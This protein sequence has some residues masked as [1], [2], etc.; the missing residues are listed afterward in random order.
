M[1]SIA[2]INDVETTQHE[3][4]P[5]AP[6][7]E[8]QEFRLTQMYHESLLHMQAG[9][10]KQAQKLLQIIIEDP[11]SL[12]AESEKTASSDPMRQLRFLSFRNLAEAF[13]K[14]GSL[15]HRAALQCY[16]NA[17]S[18]DE[19]DVTLWN[20]LGTLACSLDSLN[21]ARWAFEQG[22]QCSPQHWAC[23]EKLLEVLIA[24]GDEAACLPVIKCLLRIS[25]SHPRAILV[26]QVIE[27]NANPADLTDA[28]EML[29]NHSVLLRGIDK[30]KP[31]HYSLSFSKKRK[32]EDLTDTN[33]STSKHVLQ[34]DLKEPSL[35]ELLNKLLEVLEG[36]NGTVLTNMHGSDK[37]TAST[38]LD[39]E[40]VS[41]GDII[42]EEIP[43]VVANAALKF[44]LRGKDVIVI[45]DPT[46]TA[47]YIDLESRTLSASKEILCGEIDIAP[48]MKKTKRD[49]F[50]TTDTCSDKAV[51]MKERDASPDEEPPLERRSTRL[52]R[53]RTRNYDKND[54]QESVQQDATRNKVSIENVLK[55]L[56]PFI[57][58][59]GTLDNDSK[60]TVNS[61]DEDKVQPLNFLEE[62]YIWSFLKKITLNS[63]VYHVAQ[64]LLEDVSFNCVKPLECWDN[65]FQVEKYIRSASK[66]PSPFCSL[67]LAEVY[68]DMTSF[69]AGVLERKVFLKECDYH[70]CRILGCIAATFPSDISAIGPTVPKNLNSLN[71]QW[72]RMEEETEVPFEKLAG[73]QWSFWVRFYWVSGRAHYYHQNCEEAREDFSKCLRVLQA[74]REY[75]IDAPVV[76]LPHCK[77]DK[78]ISVEMVQ[79]K[80]HEVQIQDILSH[81][82][83]QML[84]GGRFSELIETLAP[85]L[86]SEAEN[87]G[88]SFL[89][90]KKHASEFSTE[91]AALSMLISACEKRE[92][93]N[94]DMALRSYIQ[95][96]HIHLFAAGIVKLKGFPDSLVQGVGQL[97]E[98]VTK[99]DSFKLVVEEVKRLSRFLAD[100][101]QE[102]SEKPSAVVVDAK[103]LGC[104]QQLLLTIMCHLLTS[105]AVQ[106]LSSLAGVASDVLEQSEA[107]CLV[108]A[109]VSFCRLQH[110]YT[111][112]CIEDQVELLV[113][114]H[115]L[116]ADRGL[117][118]AGKACE[119]GE[120]VF[121]KMAIRYF[122]LLEMKLK[123]TKP[124]ENASI[125]EET[126]H[127]LKDAN[128]NEKE[129]ASTAHEDAS[130]GVGGVLEGE[131]R[132]EEL[133]GNS[134][135][136]RSKPLSLTDCSEQICHLEKRKTDLGLDI[137][138]DQSFFCL[139]G[140]N[141]RGGLE[142]SGSQDGLAVHAN[143]SLGDYQTQ[144]QCAEVFQYLLPYARVC[145]K[146]SLAKLRKVLR[147]IKQHFPDPPE[148]VL[149]N[150]SIDFFL[151]DIDLDESKLSSMILSR[152]GI[153]E[154]LGY[155]LRKA[156]SNSGSGVGF[157]EVSDNGGDAEDR[158]I[159]GNM[160]SS[161]YKEV[162]EN[163]YYLLGQVEEG[164]ASDKWPGFVLTKE[165]EDFVEQNAKLIKYDLM[166]NNLRF[167]S[168]HKLANLLDE[169][170]DLM[171][172]DGSKTC[173]ALEWHKNADL[174]KR[175]ETGRR[176]TRRCLLMSMAL[177]KTLE[178]ERS[179]HELLAL[180]YYDTLQ[181]VAPCYNQR[182]HIAARDAA[183]REVCQKSLLHFEKALSFRSEWL[184]FF[185]LGKLCEKLGEPC[186]VVLQYYQE[187]VQ[188]NPSAVDSLYRLHASRLKWLCNK[189]ATDLETMKIIAKYSYDTGTQEKVD[190]LILA[191]EASVDLAKDGSQASLQIMPELPAEKVANSVWNTLLED[192]IK[193]LEVCTEGELKHF[194]KA[195]YRLAQ[196]LYA[197]GKEN[198]IERAKEELGF[199]FRS[200]R[201]LFIIN[202]WEID[203]TTKKNR[204]K[205]PASTGARRSYEITMPES[206]RKFITCLRKYLLFY[207][208]LCEETFDVCTLERAY[209][210]LRGDKKFSLCLADMVH[211]ALGK[212]I[213]TLGAAIFQFDMVGIVPNLSVKNLLERF[214]NLF[215]E[216]G[217]SLSDIVA[218]SLAEA[219]INPAA[220]LSEN[221]I[222]SYIHRYLHN[223]E[224]ENKVDILEVVNEKIKKRFKTPKLVKE[225]CARV[226]KHAAIAWCRCLCA[227]LSAITPLQSQSIVAE[228]RSDGKLSQEQLVVELRIDELFSNMSDFSV[229]FEDI[230]TTEQFRHLSCMAGVRIQQATSENTER[231]FCLLKQAFLFYRDCTGPFPAGINLFLVQPGSLSDEMMATAV[232]ASTSLAGVDLS[233]PRK[234]LLWAYSLVHGH[235]CSI[236]EAVRCCEDQAK[237]KAKKG[238]PQVLL[239]ISCQDKPPTGSGSGIRSS[240]DDVVEDKEKV[241][242]DVDKPPLKEAILSSDDG[243]KISNDDV[244]DEKEKHI[245]EEHDVEGCQSTLVC[246]S[247]ASSQG[248]SGPPPSL[249]A[250]DSAQKEESCRTSVFDFVDL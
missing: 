38:A 248:A 36:I 39:S 192:G 166:Y 229:P 172:N 34:L 167:E 143:T 152:T 204:R 164:S 16:L 105:Q 126:Q 60:K 43:S 21:I 8:A 91:L 238:L 148:E 66:A 209:C 177:A 64:K 37:F 96:M 97:V 165:G 15:F 45:E 90:G 246:A 115:D 162:Y 249:L 159:D 65:L 58:C 232:P 214:F 49:A 145:T 206:S 47:E 94:F 247:D 140:L 221:T 68:M 1:F 123:S 111:G 175:V 158:Q 99:K 227:S 183:W 120:G 114:I 31:Y 187:A 144:E 54:E 108:D 52:E 124:D 122:L 32:F 87:E 118:C 57:I 7:K 59:K 242:P 179:V 56:E 70:L 73:C 77:V 182:Q 161:Q 67:F 86:F 211:V 75:E 112:A 119:G 198:D 121:L 92:P 22:L 185:Y 240:N 84:E 106:K 62:R 138:L 35:I 213:H 193:A 176:R 134:L 154:I 50:T 69:V 20:R 149:E 226:C 237:I 169:E 101:D 217:G 19:K 79:N 12:N 76:N 184:Y 30:L 163:L 133:E 26:K 5:L 81:S 55:L 190:G 29:N 53:I 42:L 74:R 188:S 137:A 223:L 202:M 33:E 210:S 142:S 153:E 136:K 17:V 3:W 199:C 82:A 250:G 219:G 61:V 151:D 46:A 100:A 191:I 93:R 155:A 197:R 234:L 80:L 168:W 104:M 141:L 109:A 241:I 131:K 218:I 98:D 235:T 203:G 171:L 146:A 239:P 160:K 132:L 230:K 195:R 129:C 4:Q 78:Q 28:V 127:N 117:C 110:L 48:C 125:V 116:L 178:Q 9:E 231:A 222:H 196:C 157:S 6:T 130:L 150:N 72:P 233:V 44:S 13:L 225:V 245:P 228:L 128:K 208:R 156:S 194:H 181:N 14:Q 207:L 89:A 189:G 71:V 147:A 18:I 244:M 40:M 63:G 10:Y 51:T 25:P 243:T 224:V 103:L 201:S 173:S 212:Y 2:A 24:I 220:A 174:M 95:R 88:L 83:A 107:T 139:Y 23:M 102:F 216:H 41:S 180:V 236:A 11:L 85:I 113:K 200:N 135:E 170:V 205:M 27:N 215:M 186:E